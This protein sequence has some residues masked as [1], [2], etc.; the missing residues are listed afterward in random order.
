MGNYRPS[1]S[2]FELAIYRIRI[3]GILDKLWSD[4]CRGM[5]IEYQNDLHLGSM[6]VLTDGKK[7]QG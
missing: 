7:A 2:L 1:T 6:S 4:Y 3:L 5:T